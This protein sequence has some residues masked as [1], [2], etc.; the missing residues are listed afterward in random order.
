MVRERRSR[1]TVFLTLSSE[2]ATWALIGSVVSAAI[3]RGQRPD[4]ARLVREHV[5]LAGG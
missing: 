2:R 3:L 5:E 4:L 1:Q